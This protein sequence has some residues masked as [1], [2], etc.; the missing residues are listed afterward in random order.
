MEDMLI[1]LEETRMSYA[2]SASFLVM[3][4]TN[5]EIGLIILL[6]RNKE[7]VLQE[8]SDLGVDNVLEETLG[9][10]PQ[11]TPSFVNPQGAP[12]FY[13][14]YTPTAIYAGNAGSN[15]RNVSSGTICNISGSNDGV[16][17]ADYNVVVDQAWYIDSG[18]TN[19]VTQNAGQE[20]KDHIA[21]GDC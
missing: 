21:Q 16:T 15:S 2:R 10:Q 13:N 11:M 5:A 9:Y 18:A 1:L 4:L 8:A 6:F 7:E 12:G 20:Y 19:H 17:L 14:V 3:E